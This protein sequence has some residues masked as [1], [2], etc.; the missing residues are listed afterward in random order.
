MKPL[1]LFSAIVARAALILFFLAA[2]L[3]ARADTFTNGVTGSALPAA[4]ALD[5]TE[6]SFVIQA[7]VT[8]TATVAQIVAG[9]LAAITTASNYFALVSSTNATALLTV[10]NYL[11]SVAKTNA[12][13]LTTAS[14][15][16]SV[17]LAS[18]SNAVTTASNSLAGQLGGY[19]P[20]S[21]PASYQ[22]AA[23]VTAAATA[24]V[25]TY[26]TTG[27]TNGG[28]ATLTNLNFA[29]L[30]L[31]T[32]AD[33]TY[34]VNMAAASMQIFSY[35]N[36]SNFSLSFSNYTAGQSVTVLVVN[37]STSS[38]NLYINGP[39]HNYTPS[40][41]PSA[42]FGSAIVTI[43]STSANPV[44]AYVNAVAQ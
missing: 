22:T 32:I 42:N 24:A 8:K 6:K 40:V 19:Y 34:V 11:A 29:P 35:T 41:S 38:H 5:G 21:N 16:L 36:N 43:L 23:Q 28:S 17:A 30:N 27:I 3:V 18:V 10:S 9:P 14:N 2:A 44:G 20:T 12:N 7:A 13:N 39:S 4:S 1:I 31:G 26:A 15:T 37:K 33:V 25:N